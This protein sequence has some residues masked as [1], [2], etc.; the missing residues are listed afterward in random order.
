MVLRSRLSF[1]S[2]SLEEIF[3]SCRDEFSATVREL[4][5]NNEL[6]KAYT[7]ACRQYFTDPG[8]CSLAVSFFNELGRSDLENQLISLQ[9]YS[10]LIGEAVEKAREIFKSKT[11]VNLAF[12]SFL[13][14]AA[15]IILV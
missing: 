3:L 2:F 14:T 1:S 4:M 7:L 10:R 5:K 8:D 9:N 13:G 11:R 6:P 15:A 12:Y